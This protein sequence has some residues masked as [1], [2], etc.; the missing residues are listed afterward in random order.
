MASLS[1]N[2][3]GTALVLEDGSVYVWGS[4]DAWIDPM[5]GVPSVIRETPVRVERLLDANGIEIEACRAK[6][7]LTA[8]LHHDALR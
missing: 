2:A 6:A 8:A 7:V 1:S 5:A 4:L 3:V